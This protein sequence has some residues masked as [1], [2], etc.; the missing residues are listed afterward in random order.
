MLK[1][2]SLLAALIT[3][4]A[5]CVCVAQALQTGKKVS[6]L[7]SYMGGNGKVQTQH[8]ER[9][10]FV[11][12]ELVSKKSVVTLSPDADGYAGRIVG[13]RYIYT[14][15]RNKVFD[16]KAGRFLDGYPVLHEEVASEE[17]PGLVSP[18]GLKSVQVSGPFEGSADSLEIHFAGKPTVFVRENFQVYVNRLSSYMPR[19]P[20]LWIDA[21]RI[22]TQKSNG[23][24]VIVSTDGAVSPF[25]Q[26][27]CAADRSPALE[28]NRSDKIVY[29]C[30]GG[31]Y[32]IDVGK[33]RYEKIK[34]DLGN[35]FALDHMDGNI[36]Y[37]YKD[38]EIGREGTD[39]VTTKSY[40]ALLYAEA[41]NGVI[42][43][44]EIKTVKVWSE[45]KRSWTT[46]KVDGRG[47]RIL[48]WFE[49]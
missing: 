27:P 13:G 11:E 32:L 2:K 45:A 36:V 47:A 46:I 3:F 42:D 44:D 1:M 12:G 38:E 35:G 25:L 19:L 43:A 24:L 39:A 14:A 33:R 34:T 17:L 20:L 8:V 6:L 28:R 16:L 15:Y 18:D 29:E 7:V 9:F 5:S 23:N 37:Y 26:I 48:G 4:S 41:K 49:E 10:D 40:L 31:T 21:D 30:D 22:L